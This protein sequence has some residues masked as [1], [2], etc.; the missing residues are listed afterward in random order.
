[1]SE[2]DGLIAFPSRA[3]MAARL[4]DLIALRLQA[5]I[6]KRGR[7]LFAASGGSTPKP[8][9]E[10]LSAANIDWTRIDVTLV[11]ERWLAPGAPGSNE[12]SVRETLL[13]NRAAAANFTGL[14]TA[15][16]DPFAAAPAVNA[17]LDALAFPID[18]AVMGIGADGHTASWFPNAE[19]LTA[20]LDAA[21]Q[22]K[23][24]AIRAQKSD[25]T[26]D[27]LDRMTLTL[28]TIARAKLV[29]LIMTGPDKHETF[30]AARAGGDEK[31]MPVRALLHAAPELWACWAP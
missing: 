8:L 10:A 25:V 27:F 31:D 22:T 5:S 12:T 21:G 17:A 11:D 19:G 6:A 16:A 24:V 28:P 4:A 23:A 20:A 30:E 1:M 14:K 29:V 2:T 3:A 15:E 18:V 7:A 26:G 9:Y 13:K